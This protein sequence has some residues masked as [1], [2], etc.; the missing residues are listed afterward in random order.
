MEIT[1]FLCG[2]SFNYPQKLF[3]HLNNCGLQTKIFF[4]CTF[5]NCFQKFHL[6]RSY[7]KHI[8]N[9]FQN[10]LS[11]LHNDNPVQSEQDLI[12]DSTQDKNNIENFVHEVEITNQV[13]KKS[14]HH[15]TYKRKL[16]GLHD[17]MSKIIIKLHSFNN[18][19]RSD[20]SS[21]KDLFEDLLNPLLNIFEETAIS[22][23]ESIVDLL[24]DIR[25]LL[26][27]F[28]SEFKFNKALMKKD[29][30]G[31]V[32]SFEINNNSSSKGI[33]M[34]LEFQLRKVF[35]QN[36]YLQ[37]M[38]E[39]MEKMKNESKYKNFVQG[40]LWKQ[41]KSLYP[42][43]IVIPFFLYTDDFGINNPLGSKSN[44]HSICNFYYSFSCNPMKSSK[45][46]EVFLAYSI[47]S[48]DFKKY[49]NDCL[50]PL[51]NDLK[52]LEV[53][54]IDIKTNG[55]VERVHFVMALLL[56]DNLGLNTTLGFAKSFSSNYYCRFC[57][58]K[59]SDAQQECCENSNLL[60]NR[61][62]YRESLNRGLENGISGP[63][64]FNEIPSFHCTENFAV[65]V[66][67]DLFEGVCHNIFG[68]SLQ[69]FIKKMKY[70]TLDEF[71]Q[72]LKVFS[73]DSHDR[74]TEKLQVSNFEIE[75]C[76]FKTS[77]KQMLS[78][79]HYFT[80]LV[81]EFIPNGDQ[82][83]SFLLVFLELVDDILS[84]EV[85]DT[86]IIEIGSKIN[87]VL[88]NYQVLFKKTLTPKFHFLLHYTRVLRQ[89]GPLRNLW[90]FKYEGKHK[91][92][93]IYSHV[94]TSRKNIPKSFAFKQQMQFANFLIEN[95][96]KIDQILKNPIQ[97]NNM[98]QLI[99]NI[100]KINTIEFSIYT[101][102]EIW[103]Y[104]Y[105]ENKII[106]VF[107]NDFE[108]YNICAVIK[109]S[110]E[111]LFYCKRILSSY[112]THFIAFKFLETTDSHYIIN[113]NELIGPPVD[114]LKTSRGLTL[115]KI[116]EFYKP[117][118]RN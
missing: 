48:A 31:N 8:I 91:Q 36:N 82:V 79:C 71:N 44:K 87:Y 101:A 110:N 103:G 2:S 41:K 40:E 60:R 94:I 116:K 98:K 67:H 20:V 100:L 84:Y 29:L 13:N 7:Q 61:I 115:I 5:K 108:L 111:I 15:D 59:K 52:K 64:I 78:F 14:L 24:R 30:V 54:G 19:S 58:T 109:T 88:Q 38:L 107:K 62:N 63:C 45:F 104:Q 117:I 23:K 25:E 50:K 17:C 86:K 53:N 46:D 99:A 47:K 69:Y 56:G 6:K 26:K 10:K 113:L 49:G 97:D 27:S 42:N 16:S 21:I 11:I 102:A 106:T 96:P 112:D 92:F 32:Q 3:S 51:I 80:L 4:E 74:G 85:C 81:G 18:L 12:N 34:P 35:E 77:A 93:K 76:K 1:C 33:M 68:E 22:H 43:K 118:C 114:K 9:H 66:M 37:Q 70:F 39:H 73:Y 95:K 72:R 89:C 28:K 75:N 105:K 90:S 55:K 65:D 57:M 83:W